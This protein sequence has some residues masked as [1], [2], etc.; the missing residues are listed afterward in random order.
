ML[1]SVEII[2]EDEVVVE[3]PKELQTI[4]K[5]ALKKQRGIN[6]R[7]QKFIEEYLIDFN[8]RRAAEAAGYSNAT[9][10]QASDFL[11]R[12]QVK[13]E[14]LSRVN[15]ISEKSGFQAVRAVREAMWLAYSDY[16]DY[17]E[18]DPIDDE[19]RLKPI[20]SLPKS[21]TAAIKKITQSFDRDTGKPYVSGI[22]LY[23]KQKS[24]ELLFKYLQIAPNTLKITGHDGG[25]IKIGSVN[26]NATMNEKEAVGL[27]QELLMSKK[28]S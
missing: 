6:L 22:E 15:E 23:D 17:V 1:D 11:D 13:S 10:I 28:E 5:H 25:A 26:V 18:H 8:A 4:K 3:E 9:A 12:P 20:H 16:S 7:E 2:E 21:K 27:F 19:Y 24:L 14:I